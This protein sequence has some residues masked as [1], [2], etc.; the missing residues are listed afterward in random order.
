VGTDTR[1]S[2]VFSLAGLF[3]SA[4]IAYIASADPVRSAGA[5]A[6][7][8][9]LGYV[10]GALL[11]PPPPGGE[12]LS[13]TLL[14][15]VAG[16]FL[17]TLTFLFSL[18]L[19]LPWFAGPGVVFA[20][21]IVARRWAA[22]LPPRLHLHAD[23]RGMV[24]ALLAAILLAPAVIASLQMGRGPFPEV[25]FNVDTPYVLEKVHALVRAGSYPPPSLGVAGGIAVNHYGVQ[26]V[27]A[28]ISLGSGL[29]AHHVLFLIVV[30]LLGIGIAAAA[31]A[32]A[33]IQ[34]PRI[35]A[36]IAVPLLLIPVPT[37][38][39]PFWS[40]IGHALEE[41]MGGAGLTPLDSLTANV[42]MW[43]VT[44]NPATS[45]ASIF[46]VLA[47]LAGIAAAPARGWGLAVFL[48]GSAVAFK[49]PTGVAL[50]TGLGVFLI[51]T[52]FATRS[53]RPLVPGLATAAVFGLVYV[54]L[55]LLADNP[56]NSSSVEPAFLYHLRLLGQREG[57][58]GFWRDVIWLCLPVGVLIATGWRSGRSVR[59]ARRWDSLPLLA[60]AL[61]PLL[62]VNTLH[63]L[64][65]GPEGLRPDANWLQVLVPLATVFHAFVLRLGNDW[66]DLVGRIGRA[67]FVAVIALAILPSVFVA[68]RYGRTLLVDRVRGQEFVDNRTLGAAL[69]TIP[70][71]G[72]LIVTNDLRYPADGFSRDDRQMQ[73]PALFG[74]TAFAVNFAYEYYSFS[75]ERRHTQ[76]LLR[77][78]FWNPAIDHAARQYGWTHLL[79]R[80]DY[81]HPA[82]VPLPKVF[83]NGTYSVYRFTHATDLRA[84]ASD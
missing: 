58:P 56:D 63:L 67:S 26:G 75:E 68:G 40:D 15:L 9:A 83:D 45:L 33:R 61:T 73:I 57:L 66:W 84:K 42:Q 7:V 47:S 38:W 27:A 76:S 34:S 72:T 55:F 13:L 23:R 60:F 12:S 19:G 5:V 3:V 39:Y 17:S 22:L 69:A 44:F 10:P 1:S 54:A 59:Q 16:L 62:V 29:A 65:R 14:R 35:P 82:T 25:F 70:V 37:L 24:A 48:I 18:V 8:Y 4:G 74:H 49:A 78:A 31:A 43:A 36:W 41:T 46:L 50:A 79:I 30:P 32:M 21:A 64:D 77:G 52:A 28:L 11:L 53:H 71:A 81:P 51:C 20:T 6:L 80:N 2:I